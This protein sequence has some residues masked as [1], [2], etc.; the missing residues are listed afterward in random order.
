MKCHA[1]LRAA[2]Y[3]RS[4]TAYICEAFQLHRGKGFPTTDV[5][6]MAIRDA[7]KAVTRAIGPPR[8]APE[9]PLRWLAALREKGPRDESCG[10]WPND[11]YEVW[12]FGTRFILREQELACIFTQEIEM[13]HRLQQVTLNLPVT[14]SNAMGRGARRTLGCI[15][16]KCPALRN[17]RRAE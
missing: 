11:G 12:V 15:C 9:V 1:A 5:L 13:N 6:H 10:A 14:K 17:R 4:A 3:R 8:R 16:S 7:K 2:G